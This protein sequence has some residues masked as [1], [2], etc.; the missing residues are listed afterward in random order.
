MAGFAYSDAMKKA[1]GEW[2][3]EQLDAFIANPKV[4]V[5]GTKMTFAGSK[6]A[7]ERANLIAFLRSK[8]DS[9]KPLP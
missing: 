1:S 6:D 9:P 5:P 7:K 8:S 2:S 3:Y 4:A